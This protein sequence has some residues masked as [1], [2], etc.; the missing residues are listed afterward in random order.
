M[1]IPFG[2]SQHND[3]LKL[4]DYIAILHSPVSDETFFV[5]KNDVDSLIG[6]LN[7]AKQYWD[8]KEKENV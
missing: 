1:K 6:A 2:D 7:K 3:Y 8:E 5:Y 4:N